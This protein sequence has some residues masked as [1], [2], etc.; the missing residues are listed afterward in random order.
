METAMSAAVV[1]SHA[2]RSKGSRAS[3]R[4]VATTRRIS[5]M[6][7]RRVPI[8]RQSPHRLGCGL[9]RHSPPRHLQAEDGARER[10]APRCH[11]AR[12]PGGAALR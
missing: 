4:R 10:V 6:A 9:P 3:V 8:A 7:L 1:R 12:A 5:S 11:A 2:G